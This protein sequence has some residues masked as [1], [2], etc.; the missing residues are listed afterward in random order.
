MD[1]SPLAWVAFAILIILCLA[2]DLWLSHRRGQSMRAALAMTAFWIALALIFGIV[3]LEFMGHESAAEYYTGYAIE[4]AMSLDTLFVFMFVFSYFGVP[5]EHRHRVLIFGI[6]GALVFRALLIFLGVQI[7]ESFSFVLPVLGVFMLYT[8]IKTATRKENERPNLA[9]NPVVRLFKR[10]FPTTE[11]YDG[12][13][14]FTLK[15]GVRTATPLLIALVALES[16]DIMFAVDSIPAVMAITT[17]T[18][19]IYTSN[20]FAML[21]LR[22]LYSVLDGSLQSFRYLKYGLGAI[23]AFVGAKI[24]VHYFLHI[25]VPVLV[26][27]AVIILAM[28]L[29]IAASALSDRRE[30]GSAA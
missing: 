29:S 14:F 17:D 27:L 24:L 2:L 1:L 26:S 25:E 10:L 19:I 23:L 30:K 13:N 8:A 15:D 21:G 20:V 3:V 11:E 9:K 6:V 22:A 16:T 12:D 4:K 7:I 18:F 5:R 28:V